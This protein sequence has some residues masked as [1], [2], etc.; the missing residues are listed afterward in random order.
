MGA[1]Q[2]GKRKSRRVLISGQTFVWGASYPGMVERIVPSC[3][4]ARTAEHNQSI[5]RALSLT[6]QLD[7][8][9]GRRAYVLHRP[10][11]CY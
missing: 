4:A 6:L 11:R 1:C 3:G 2:V 9:N 8:V 5:L 7:P 10:L